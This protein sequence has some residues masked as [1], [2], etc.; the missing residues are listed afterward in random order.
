M[1]INYRQ[2]WRS[3]YS[4]CLPTPRRHGDWWIIERRKVIV[5]GSDHCDCEGFLCLPR[6]S[7]KG[8]SSGSRVACGSSSCVGCAA[9]GCGLGMWCL[10]ARE[11]PSEWITTT[12]TSLPSSKWT[13]EEK[14]LFHHYLRVSYCDWLIISCRSG[15]THYLCCVFTFKV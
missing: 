4:W 6:Q 2:Q 15:I 8:N 3:C 1:D 11:P 7:A 10:L 12:G 14:S 13:S 5:S 9:P